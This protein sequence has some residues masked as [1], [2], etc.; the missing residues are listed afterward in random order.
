MTELVFLKGKQPVTTS[1]I[2]AEKFEKLHKDV[3]EKIRFLSAEISADVPIE[4]FSPKFIASTYKDVEGRV[5]PLYLLNRDAFTELVGNLNGRNA[6]VWKRKYHEK[7]LAERQSAEW[8]EIRSETKRGYKTLSAAVHELYEFAVAHG[9]K[10]SEKVFYIN[11]A[12]LLNKTLGIGAG[13][14][15][16]LAAWQLYEVEKLQFIARTVIAGLLAQAT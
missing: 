1:L 12:K 11:F 15:D 16:E 6:R 14:R 10:A 3:L 8:Q 5:Q 9:C 4:G 7:I 2:V 13:T